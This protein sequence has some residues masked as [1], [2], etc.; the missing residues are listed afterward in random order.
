MLNLWMVSGYLKE[1]SY[2][3]GY[4][5]VKLWVHVLSDVVLL[6]WVPTWVTGVSNKV[7]PCIVL[8]P[9]LPQP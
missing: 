9:I 8:V 7:K 5:G 4:G 6:E 3:R 2:T 1:S